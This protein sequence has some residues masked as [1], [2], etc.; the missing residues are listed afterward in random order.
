MFILK[1]KEKLIAYYYTDKKENYN[2][3][4]IILISGKKKDIYNNTVDNTFNYKKYLYNQ[5]I[6]NVIEITN[7]NK[8]KSNI[9]YKNHNYVSYGLKIVPS[10]AKAFELYNLI[11]YLTNKKK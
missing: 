2:L 4:D 7:I 9:Y 11:D 3:G 5:G 6:Y 8:I 10:D 1:G